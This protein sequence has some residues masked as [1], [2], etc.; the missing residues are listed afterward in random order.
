[1]ELQT[2]DP[3]RGAGTS[4]SGTLRLAYVGVLLL[5]LVA[6]NFGADAPAAV[7]PQARLPNIVLIVIDTLRPDHL[8]CYGHDR[9]TSPRIDRLAA[10]GVVFE[11]CYSVASWTQPAMAS[12][13][14]G[15]LPAAHGCVSAESKIPDVLPVL[16]EKLREKGYSCLGVVSNPHLIAKYGF[17][18][19]FDRYDDYTVFLDA[20]TGLLSADTSRERGTVNDVVTG[21]TVTRQAI[22]LLEQTAESGKPFFLFALYFDP[23]DSYVPTEPYRRR[24]ASSYSGAITGRGVRAMRDEPPASEDLAQ[25]VNLYEAEV[26]YT[27]DQVGRLLKAIGAISK[28]A[29]TLTIIVSDHGEAFGEHGKLLHGNSVHPEETLVPMIWHWPGRFASGH[30][31][32]APVAN[33]DIAGTLVLLAISSDTY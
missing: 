4:R 21:A 10:E 30:R 20:E 18:R 32:T 16:G 6:Q 11:Q 23:H 26:A 15:L 8:G 25:L 1:M 27:D 5:V 13:F 2:T 17:G 24:F 9:G 28:P 7:P 22:A 14:T 31:V 29:D 3:R 33:F 12:I 19:G